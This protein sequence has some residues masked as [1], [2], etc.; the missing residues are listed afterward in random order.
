[1]NGKNEQVVEKMLSE[2]A[3][4]FGGVG[5]VLADQGQVAGILVDGLCG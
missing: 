4:A 2:I 3:H 5:Q 1:M